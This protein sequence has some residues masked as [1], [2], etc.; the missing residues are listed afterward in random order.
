MWNPSDACD[1]VFLLLW[2]D[3]FNSPYARDS[4]RMCCRCIKHEFLQ[5]AVTFCLYFFCCPLSLLGRCMRCYLRKYI[6]PRRF[7][8]L[9]ARGDAPSRFR[10][11]ES[12]ADEYL[13]YMEELV[14]KVACRLMAAA[15]SIRIAGITEPAQ[16]VEAELD[17]VQAII[18]FGWAIS[19][20]ERILW[21]IQLLLI[22][23]VECDVIIVEF[24][25]IHKFTSIHICVITLIY[26]FGNILWLFF[27]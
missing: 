11:S 14:S 7:F 21:S 12:H 5:M 27:S 13:D 6:F 16:S 3:T 26:S 4:L 2:S 9:H 20:D 25:F 22:A 10:V 18:V 1:G 8:L 23:D 24:S 19:F 17:G 15:Q